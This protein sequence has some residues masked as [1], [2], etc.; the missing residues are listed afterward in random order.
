VLVLLMVWITPDKGKI[1]LV[2]DD[3]TSDVVMNGVYVVW[4]ALNF[5]LSYRLFCRRQVIGRFV[6]V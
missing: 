5:W 1:E 3:T 6:N 2:K 4:V